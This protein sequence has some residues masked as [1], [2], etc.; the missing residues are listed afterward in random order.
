M[1]MIDTP[2]KISHLAGN[3]TCNQWDE[4]ERW[5]HER[6]VDRSEIPRRMVL[7]HKVCQSKTTRHGSVDEQEVTIVSP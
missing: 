4:Q 1:A 7:L 3:E 2:A 5:T 6:R